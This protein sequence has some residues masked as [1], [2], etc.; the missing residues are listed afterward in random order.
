MS[1]AGQ[2]K[3]AERVVSLRVEAKLMTIAGVLLLA[4]G[5]PATLALAALAMA[6]GAVEP[7]TPVW[8]GGPLIALGW[9]CCALASARLEQARQLSAWLGDAP[10]VALEAAHDPALEPTAQ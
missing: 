7:L 1:E 9:A 4:T 5:F 6:T 3:A 10:G 2:T 8:A